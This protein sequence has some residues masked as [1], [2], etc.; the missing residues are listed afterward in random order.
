MCVG[1]LYKVILRA[2]LGLIMSRLLNNILYPYGNRK[3]YKHK[4][5]DLRFYTICHYR[6]VIIIVLIHITACLILK[7][8]ILN[9]P[10]VVEIKNNQKSRNYYECIE[11]ND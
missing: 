1:C 4:G 7:L 5:S 9:F 10:E 11:E 8:V 3:K 2:D 6:L